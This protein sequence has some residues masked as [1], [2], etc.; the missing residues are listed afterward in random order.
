VGINT[1]G[2]DRLQE[3]EP[4]YSTGTPRRRLIENADSLELKINDILSIPKF[5]D[6][7]VL[8]VLWIRADR[9]Q[10]RLGVKFKMAFDIDVLV[11]S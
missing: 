3:P 9:Y 10:I 1:R 7:Q 5:G 6:V 4:D 8:S 2:Y 11:M